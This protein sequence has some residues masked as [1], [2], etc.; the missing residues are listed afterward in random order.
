MLEGTACTQ[1]AGGPL[2][3]SDGRA[4]ALPWA[5]TPLTWPALRCT[6]HCGSSLRS[7]GIAGGSHAT[8]LAELNPHMAAMWMCRAG[9]HLR[10]IQ[11][12]ATL[13]KYHCCEGSSLARSRGLRPSRSSASSKNCCCAF[14]ASAK[15]SLTMSHC[16]RERQKSG[17]L[18]VAAAFWVAVNAR[19]AL[20]PPHHELLQQRWQLLGCIRGTATLAVLHS[21]GQ[22]KS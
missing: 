3:P 11:K 12:V 14:W 9:V 19:T 7:Q 17:Q 4:V 20:K 15:S 16:S 5:R 21:L 6:N 1:A 13:K 22:H 8:L 2:H 18:A 10:Y